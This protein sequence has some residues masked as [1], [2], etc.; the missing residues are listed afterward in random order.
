MWNPDDAIDLAKSFVRDANATDS[1]AVDTSCEWHG[2]QYREV[3]TKALKDW[4][5]TELPVE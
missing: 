2:Q 3:I 1:D 4:N 5:R